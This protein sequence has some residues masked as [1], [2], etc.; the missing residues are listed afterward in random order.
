MT[1]SCP[2]CEKSLEKHTRNQLI[3]CLVKQLETVNDL[4][5]QIKSHWDLNRNG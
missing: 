4:E 3:T 1:E 5:R 2:V